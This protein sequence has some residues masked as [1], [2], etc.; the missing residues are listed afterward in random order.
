MLASGGQCLTGVGCVVQEL[1]R[2]GDV[3]ISTWA[4]HFFVHFSLLCY[5]DASLRSSILRD[6][7]HFDVE[8]ELPLTKEWF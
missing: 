3:M 2:L 4:F 5:L 8:V 7:L 6:R 1:L